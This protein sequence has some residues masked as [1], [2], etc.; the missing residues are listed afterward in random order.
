MNNTEKVRTVL[1]K[2]QVESQLNLKCKLTSCV[3]QVI[4]SVN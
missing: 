1:L 2:P 4:L 3:F